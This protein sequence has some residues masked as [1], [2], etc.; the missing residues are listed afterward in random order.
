MFVSKY[1]DNLFSSSV[2]QKS[3]HASS[4]SFLTVG[5]REPFWPCIP[6][7]V[8]SFPPYRCDQTLL[9]PPP[10]PRY[11]G[12]DKLE[13]QLHSLSLPPCQESYRLGQ[14]RSHGIELKAT[15]TPHCP[16]NCM[17]QKRPLFSGSEGANGTGRFVFPFWVPCGC[18]D[19]DT[20]SSSALP[21]QGSSWL[22]MAMNLLTLLAKFFWGTIDFS[23]H[24]Y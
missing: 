20:F 22:S 16:Q 23:F 2:V 12:Q 1:W 9:P 7:K 6:H 4:V 15:T 19:H 8:L 5:Y 14:A 24:F 3:G 21:L 10:H 11:L 13:L 18:L 17:G